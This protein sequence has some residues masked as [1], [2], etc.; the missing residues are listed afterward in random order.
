MTI[1]LRK[2]RPEDYAFIRRIHHRTMEAYVKDFF[3]SW[4][5]DYQDKRFASQFKI[6]EARIIVC[7][8]SDIGW[9]AKRELPKEILVTDIFVAPEHQNG[10]IGTII[11][12]DLISEAR[13]EGKSVSLSVMKN[14]PARRLYERVG[15]K[16]IGENEYK[17]F[18][19]Y[20]TAGGGE[21]QG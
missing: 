3:C 12:R 20:E 19:R 11:L 2:A 17:F 16:V 9:L 15:F 5:Q 8:G 14:N 4:D 18:L 7:D 21:S 13:R 1:Q 6:E 10:G